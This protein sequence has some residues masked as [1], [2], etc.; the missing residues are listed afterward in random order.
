MLETLWEETESDL[1]MEEYEFL[2]YWEDRED[3]A[4]YGSDE[5][6]EL[7]I[8]RITRQWRDIK[9]EYDVL[10]LEIN[11]EV[12]VEEEENQ[13]Q[14]EEK[15]EEQDDE[16]KI[17]DNIEWKDWKEDRNILEINL[18]GLIEE[19]RDEEQEQEQE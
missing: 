15:E 5:I 9:E 4:E 19:D 1:Q 11:L 16:E 7:V 17:E 6:I 3:R 2:E 8:E 13:N 14:D 12:I 10:E 18:E